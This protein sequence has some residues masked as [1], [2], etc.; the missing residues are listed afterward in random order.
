[1]YKKTK[2]NNGIYEE[3]FNQIQNEGNPNKIIEVLGQH[4]KMTFFYLFKK[5]NSL[6]MFSQFMDRNEINPEVKNFTLL[7]VEGIDLLDRG[8]NKEDLKEIKMLSEDL[9]YSELFDFLLNFNHGSY[10]II[11]IENED[12]DYN[13]I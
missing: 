1:M 4:K 7:S 3:V 11:Y 13:K 10:D 12:K 5:E 6:I 2:L 8:F 9:N